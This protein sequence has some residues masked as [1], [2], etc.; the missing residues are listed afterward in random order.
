VDDSEPGEGYDQCKEQI[1]KRD[2]KRIT[3]TYNEPITDLIVLVLLQN[4]ITEKK[5]N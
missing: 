2:S 4:I 3:D 5:E 1:I